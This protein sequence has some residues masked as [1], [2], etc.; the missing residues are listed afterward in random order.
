M[1]SLAF[2]AALLVSTFGTAHADDPMPVEEAPPIASSPDVAPIEPEPA[3]VEPAP[4]PEAPRLQMLRVLVPS[5][6]GS[7]GSA[8]TNPSAVRRSRSRSFSA[9]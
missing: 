1:K 4:A 7:T 5:R 2:C 8:T 3:T 6:S 9:A